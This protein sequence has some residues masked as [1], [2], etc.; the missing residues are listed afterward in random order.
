MFDLVFCFHQEFRPGNSEEDESTSEAFDS[1]TQQFQI[2]KAIVPRL[3]H[4][5]HSDV[6][7][8]K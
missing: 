5:A 6:V 3:S 4:S 2:G 7:E 1:M 8:D